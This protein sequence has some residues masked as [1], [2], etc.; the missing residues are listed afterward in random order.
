MKFV[1]NVKILVRFGNECKQ[2]FIEIRNLKLPETT[3]V[4]LFQSLSF[5]LSL[6][7]EMIFGWMKRDMCEYM[8]IVWDKFFKSRLSK[9]F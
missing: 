1:L 7:F 5:S 9:F 4:Y 6:S 8:H 3:S 2:F